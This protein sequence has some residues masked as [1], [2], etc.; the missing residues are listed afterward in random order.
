VIDNELYKRATLR[1]QDQDK[2]KD[3]GD[4]GTKT[5]AE[6]GTFSYT[7]IAKEKRNRAS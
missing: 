6:E 2:D 7:F 5:F 1:I 3:K 4:K